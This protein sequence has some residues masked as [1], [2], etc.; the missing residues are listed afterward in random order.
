M[1]VESALAVALI[2]VGCGEATTEPPAVASVVVT[3]DWVTLRSLGETRQLTAY[4]HDAHGH[5]IADKS[6]R[7]TSSDITRA[8][9]TSSGLVTAS[10]N[11]TATITAIVDGITGTA[12]VLVDQVAARLAFRGA[13]SMQEATV[14]ITPPIQVALQDALGNRVADAADPVTLAIGSNP[15]AV[16]LGGTTVVPA[17]AGIATFGDLFIDQPGIGYSLV[18]TSGGLASDTTGVFD[19]F[20]RG[21]W[22]FTGTMMVPRR[23]HTATLLE[24]GKVL[25]AGWFARTAELYDPATGSFAATGNTVYV[26]GSGATATRLLDGTVLLVGGYRG[27]TLSEIYD[28][29]TGSFTDVGATRAH[30]QYHTA[31]L[32]ADGRVLL[33]GGQPDSPSG[34]QT[35]SAVELYDP[36][37][38]WFTLTDS[39]IDDRAGHAAVTLPDGRVLVVGGVQTTTPGYGKT[40]ASAEIYDPVTGTFSATGSMQWAAGAPRAV[41]LEDGTVLVVG[42]YDR[43]EVFDPATGIFTPTA[44]LATPHGS[45]S[46]TR[47]SDGIVLVAGGARDFGPV[48]TESVELYYPTSGVFVPAAALGTARE[49]H[50]ATLLLDGRVLVTGGWND[51]ELSSAEVYAVPYCTTQT[52]IGPRRR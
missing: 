43:P 2:G 45:G 30:R 7:W 34:L 50:T 4:A 41:L 26:H 42:D 23:D 44:T 5:R 47:L 27:D 13:P 20:A 17:T 39:L 35:H 31:S 9:V 40:L 19:V 3:P 12:A 46:A 51:G 16:T 52:A 10:G 32:L 22:T 25:I 38:G 6:F 37:T 15:C 24:D 48:L 49:E 1:I 33:A 14:P 18:A 21:E 36:S 11:G 29:A 28:P 8:T